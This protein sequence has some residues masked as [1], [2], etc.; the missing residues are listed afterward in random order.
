MNMFALPL[1]LMLVLV[2]ADVAGLRWLRGQRT[3]WRDVIF[4]LNSGHI[5][6]WLF[7]GLEVMLFAWLSAHLN[8]HWVTRTGALGVW[9]FAFFAW[10]FCFYWLHRLH[11]SIP[12]MWA[13]HAVHHEGEHYNLSLGVR[14][15]WYS[16]LTSIPFFAGLAVVGVPVEVF[17]LVSAF[18]YS[19]QFYNHCGTIH[20]SGWLDR[21]FVTPANH[22]V[23][24]G[25][26][27]EY[28]DKNFGGTLLLWDKLFGTYQA[29]LPRVKIR[30]GVHDAVGSANPFWANNIPVLRC[31]GLDVPRRG[32]ATPSSP[33]ADGWIASGGLILFGFA[34][35]YVRWQ[36]LL[37]SP[38]EP[39]LF[40]WIVMQTIALGALSDG[41]RSARRTWSAM[42]L[43]MPACFAGLFGWRDPL[44]CVLLALLALH[45]LA[46]LFA[47]APEA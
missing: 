23:H 4:N 46:C 38:Q 32:A 41:W 14:N 25:L 2:L 26:N 47:R 24:H 17:V 40:V 20:R 7:R 5:V 44:G 18:H 30:Y 6:M 9:I 36:G 35:Y 28:I 33:M 12:L 39:L 37:P 3:P 10:D 42:A 21:V 16:S 11:H 43:A 29:E 22:R 8:L 31:F 19:V 13:V 27:P 45:G 15:S 1:A 34:I